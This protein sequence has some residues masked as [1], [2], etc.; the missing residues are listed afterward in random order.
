MGAIAE[1]FAAFA[2]PLIDQTDGSFEQVE[3]AFTMS[4]VCYN[5]ALLPE[6]ERDKSIR[7]MQKS[8]KMDDEE[9]DAF[10]RSIVN[11]MIKRHKQMFP[12][13]H[14][15]ISNDA[16]EGRPSLATQSRPAAPGGRYTGTDRYAPCPCNSGRKYKFCCGAKSR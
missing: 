14:R 11:P 2:Q 6:D 8:L 12:G 1:S 15:R 3:R 10:Q 13:L 16:S 9:F 4:Q 5:L 7:A